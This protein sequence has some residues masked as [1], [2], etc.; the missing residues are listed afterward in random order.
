MALT[1]LSERD[2]EMRIFSKDSIEYCKLLK[3]A[4]NFIGHQG[5]QYGYI[6]NKTFFSSI[7]K[8]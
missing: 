8:K 6:D 7:E 5:K 1:R 4:I 3:Y 2:Y